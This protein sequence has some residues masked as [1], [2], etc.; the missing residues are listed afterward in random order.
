MIVKTNSWHYMLNDS[1]PFIRLN[2]PIYPL[3]YIS[4]TVA[5]ILIITLIVVLA[6][7]A[8]VMYAWGSGT[9]LVQVFELGDDVWVSGSF[10]IFGCTCAYL[11]AIYTR[12]VLSK[13]KPIGKPIKFKGNNDE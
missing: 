10:F 6:L 13:L 3:K 7:S 11:L 9:V 1:L 4:L 2:Y 8:L 5:N 12:E